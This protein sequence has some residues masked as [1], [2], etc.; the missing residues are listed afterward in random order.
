MIR[1]P[2]YEKG[3]KVKIRTDVVSDFYFKCN[4]RLIK[5]LGSTAE[6]NDFLFVVNGYFVYELKGI[7]GVWPEFYLLHTYKSVKEA[8]YFIKKETGWK[9]ELRT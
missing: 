1:E 7:P 6:V 3:Q 9:I 5:C 2:K 8:I 4:P